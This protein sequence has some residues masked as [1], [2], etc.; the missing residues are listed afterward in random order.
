MN[1]EKFV[2]WL[3]LLWMFLKV[4]ILSPSGPASIGLLYKEA[5][6]TIMTEAQFVEAVG[7][8]N[9]LPGSEALKL[10]MFVGFAAGGI[11]GVLTALL[12]AILPPTVMMLILSAILQ[13]FQHTN[14]LDGFVIGM[15]PAVA[16][17]IV[18]VA[19]DLFRATS[20]KTIDRRALIIAAL[21]A[22]AFWFELPSPFVLLGAG[23]IGV[24]LYS[25]RSYE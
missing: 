19:W 1:R 21:S 23:L 17:L 5:V 4:N 25:R 11:P 7:F 14:W 18:V 9:V 12:G 15:S 16:A 8:S 24:L 6:G 10:A 22:A 3:R 2:V 13:R 20:P